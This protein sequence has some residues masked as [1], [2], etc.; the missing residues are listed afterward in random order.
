MKL[1][2]GESINMNAI[3][4]G[5][6]KIDY[7]D[8]YIQVG[9]NINNTGIYD[10]TNINVGM[11]FEIKPG[12]MGNWT[13]ILNNDSVGLGQADGPEGT[14]ILSG[15]N[16]TIGL[17]AELPSF[18]KTPA[19]IAALFGLPANWTLSDLMKLVDP[20]FAFEARL[21]LT[22]NVNY[23]FQQY[24]VAVKIEIQS[25]AILGGLI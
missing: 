14:T 6:F 5:D 19:E 11:K 17:K 22:F 23:A 12:A 2:D 4:P 10:L 13:T 20:N 24:R 9:V 3:N 18:A 21:T 7:S 25:D 16:K 8:L 1:A 15:K